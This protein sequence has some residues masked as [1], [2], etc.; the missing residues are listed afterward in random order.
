MDSFYKGMEDKPNFAVNFKAWLHRMNRVETKNNKCKKIK[1]PYKPFLIMSLMDYY[2]ENN[3]IGEHLD[4]SKVTK[5]FYDYLTTDV[6]LWNYILG[7]DSKQDWTIGRWNDKLHKQVLQTI[8]QSPCRAMSSRGKSNVFYFDRKN[9][10]I[11]IDAENTKENVR[12]LKIK[13]KEVLKDCIPQSHYIDIDIPINSDDFYEVYIKGVINKESIPATRDSYLQHIYARKVKE[14]DG[15]QCMICG[16]DF[17]IEAAH[18]YHY[19]HL[20]KDLTMAFDPNNG[21]ALCRT[22]HGM[23][24]DNVIAFKDGKLNYCEYLMTDHFI[25]QTF[26]WKDPENMNQKQIEYGNMHYDHFYI[27]KK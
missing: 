11:F 4:V 17:G 16:N 22:C 6:T 13:C 18:L 24:N 14:R 23:H 7:D 8:L 19:S 1:Y 21:I 15:Y 9:R 10:T 27:C 12:L 20:K 2:G 25:P 26:H 5:T 3:V